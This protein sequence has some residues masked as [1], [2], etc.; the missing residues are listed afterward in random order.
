MSFHVLFIA[1]D[2]DGENAQRIPEA[3]FSGF[4]LIGSCWLCLL[5]L[6]LSQSRGL[7]VCLPSDSCHAGTKEALAVKAPGHSGELHGQLGYCCHFTHQ[8]EGGVMLGVERTQAQAHGLQVG[9]SAL[10]WSHSGILT[11]VFSPAKW[12]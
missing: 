1:K 11:S 3:V 5:Q 7:G 6:A 10:V 9:A 4:P 8:E 12:Q 2:Y